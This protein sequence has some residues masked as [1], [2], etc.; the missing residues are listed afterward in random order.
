ME[1]YTNDQTIPSSP[2]HPSQDFE[3]PEQ[4]ASVEVYNKMVISKGSKKWMG[5]DT[6]EQNDGKTDDVFEFDEDEPKSNAEILNKNEPIPMLFHHCK[7][8]SSNASLLVEAALD[9]AERDIDINTGPVKLASPQPIMMTNKLSESLYPTLRS[10]LVQSPTHQVLSRSISPTEYSVQEHNHSPHLIVDSGYPTSISPR[11][12]N[13][14]LMF[15]DRTPHYELRFS[16]SAG[17]MESFHLDESRYDLH[18]RRAEENSSDESNNVA[19]NLSLGLKGKSLQLDLSAAYK[20][21]GIDERGTFE[22]LE[23]LDMSRSSNYHHSSFVSMPPRYPHTLYEQRPYSHT[24]VL[25]VVNL[26]HSVDL[27]LPRNLHHQLVQPTNQS[28]MDPMRVIS[29]P[30]TYQSYPLSPSSYLTVPRSTH[31]PTYHH[32]SGY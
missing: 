32:Y 8:E 9:A 4:S 1:K 23:G 31:S 12:S 28:L 17:Q 7:P 20:Y 15:P 24:D 14:N 16:P 19:Q 22:P 21:E 13:Y 5:H 29:P 6:I 3:T 26:T 11:H 18:H 25:R 2:Q 10:H 30:P 27:S